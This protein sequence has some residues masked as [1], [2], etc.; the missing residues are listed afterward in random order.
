MLRALLVRTPALGAT[1]LGLRVPTNGNGSGLDPAAAVREALRPG[2]AGPAED[3]RLIVQPWGFPVGHV[4]APVRI[5]HGGRDAEMPVHHA[6]FLCRIVDDGRLEVVADGATSCCSA[7]A[8]RVF[9][10]LAADE[11]R[12]A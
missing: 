6:E 7:E 1:L 2:A 11:V 10:V 8:D 9:R 5:W 12:P 3:L 4:S